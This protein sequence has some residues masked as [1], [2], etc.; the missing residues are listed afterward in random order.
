MLPG[1]APVGAGDPGTVMGTISPI[2]RD[3]ASEQL[4]TIRSARPEDAPALLAHGLAVVS[5]GEFLLIQPDEFTF[6]EDQERD[7]IRLYTEDPGRLLIVA[8]VSGCLAGVLF[9]ECSPRKRLAH[10]GT[11]HMSV[12]REWRGQ[13]IG[14]AL[15]QTLIDWAVQHPSIEKL[16]LGVF[17]TNEA[18]IRLYRKLGFVEEGRQPREIR[19]APGRY[20]DQVLMYRFV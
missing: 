17:T 16:S 4:L 8:E 6:T 9:F 15:L 14:T 5:E 7:W 18:A 2:D 1:E 19:L 20:V 3:L 12:G 13:S 10:R 11:L